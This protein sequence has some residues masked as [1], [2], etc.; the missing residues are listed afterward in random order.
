MYTRK[1]RG[2]TSVARADY[3]HFELNDGI[4][5]NFEIDEKEGTHGEAV[6]DKASPSFRID[7]LEAFTFQ[8]LIDDAQ[9]GQEE[10]QYY[11]HEAVNC[12]ENIVQ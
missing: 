1:E 3:W 11:C 4:H 5:R 7:L 6:S 12:S 9:R 2:S 8:S 10:C